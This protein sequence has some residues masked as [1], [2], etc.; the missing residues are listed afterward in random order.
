MTYIGW[1]KIH[2]TQ[3][4]KETSKTRFKTPKTKKKCRRTAAFFAVF[5]TVAGSK[6]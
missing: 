4:S 3:N 2:I 5:V 6:Q 1:E